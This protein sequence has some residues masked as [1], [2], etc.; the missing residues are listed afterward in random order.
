MDILKYY[1]HVGVK[2]LPVNKTK[3]IHKQHKQD[4]NFL[5]IYIINTFG[6]LSKHD[7]TTHKYFLYLTI[8]TDNFILC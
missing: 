6:T 1:I 8:R 3:E 7:L 5:N 4:D 2:L